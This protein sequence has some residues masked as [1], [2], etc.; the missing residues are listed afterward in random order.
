MIGNFHTAQRIV[1][2]E[3]GFI[4][5]V[6]QITG[7]TEEEGAKALATLRKAKVVKLDAV[8]GRYTV[9]HGAYLEPEVLRNAINY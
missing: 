6:M 9:V 5:I 8:N 7:C 4:K 3:L 1:N 2:A